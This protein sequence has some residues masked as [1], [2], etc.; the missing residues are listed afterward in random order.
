MTKVNRALNYN[1][2]KGELINFLQLFDPLT[3]NHDSNALVNIDY[4]MAIDPAIY[5]ADQPGSSYW[6]E[7][8]VGRVWWDVKNAYWLDY[9]QGAD[10]SYR[11][12]HWGQLFPAASI[13]VYEWVESRVVPALYNINNQFPDMG[14]PANGTAQSYNAKVIIGNDGINYNL[15]YFWVKNKQYTES[16]G[17]KTSP[18][19]EIA[20][21]LAFG[22]DKYVA[23][24]GVNNVITYNL[25]DDFVQGQ[26]VLQVEL[27]RSTKENPQHV[28]WAL[29]NEG[30]TVLPPTTLESKMFDSLTG[31]DVAGNIVPDLSLI[32]I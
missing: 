6:A 28:E 22:P 18:V 12:K 19:G 30:D 21:L 29:L 3:N 2:A 20:R 4:T 24:S 7:E 16:R 9:Q 11:L 13:D 27:L 15:Y 17:G 10:L 23:I 31:L 5:Q 25:D 14:Q 32:H 1:P 8:S 26:Q